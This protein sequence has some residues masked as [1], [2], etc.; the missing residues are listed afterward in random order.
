MQKVNEITKINAH[1]KSFNFLSKEP[2]VYDISE[3]KK[4]AVEEEGII[5]PIERTRS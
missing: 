5:C 2:D 3:L 4:C 1:S